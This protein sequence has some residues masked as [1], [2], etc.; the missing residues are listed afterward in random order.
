[1]NVYHLAQLLINFVRG[2][3]QTLAVLRHFQCGYADAAGVYGLGRCNDHAL[4]LTQEIKRVIGCRHIGDLD[5]IFHTGSRDTL[6]LDGIAIVFEDFFQAV[7][8]TVTGRFRTN[9]RAALCT[10]GRQAGQD[11]S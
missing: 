6:A 7:D 4:L 1:M 8:R 5:V 3:D 9:T 2:S 11:C 10:A